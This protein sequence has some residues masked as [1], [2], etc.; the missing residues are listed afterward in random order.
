MASPLSLQ[1]DAAAGKDAS[2]ISETANYNFGNDYLLK[3][4]LVGPR[5]A[6]IQ[7]DVSPVPA[8]ATITTSSLSLF[9]SETTYYG[10]LDVS[11][12]RVLIDWGEGTGG[13]SEVGSCCWNSAKYGSVNWTTAGCNGADTDRSSTT[14]ATKTI[15][16]NAWNVIDGNGMVADVQA[17]VDGTAN[18]GWVIRKPVNNPYVGFFSSDYPDDTTK[19]PKLVVEYTASGGS[20]CPLQLLRPHIIPAFL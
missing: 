4:A 13:R 1:P 19:R 16:W 12:Y 10:T 20:T 5:A 18:Y 8:G 6:L 9:C 11:V 14:S 15:T 3:V 7:F 2:L 17:W